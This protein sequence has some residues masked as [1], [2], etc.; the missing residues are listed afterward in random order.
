M[1]RASGYCLMNVKVIFSRNYI[2]NKISRYAIPF[3]TWFSVL[4]SLAGISFNPNN[5]SAQGTAYVQ[6]DG[7]PP[8]LESPLLADVERSY[9]QGAFRVQFVLISPSRQPR[10]FQFRLSFEHDGDQLL[11]MVSDPISFEP[12]VYSYT[13][14]DDDPAILFPLSYDE[15]L[16][17]LNPELANT[18]ILPE[19]DYLLRIE[20]IPTDPNTLIPTVPGVALFTVRYGEPPLLLTPPDQ[21]SISAQLPIFSWTPVTGV[22]L[23]STIEYELL[24]SEVLSEQTPAQA[25]ESNIEQAHKALISQTSFVYTPTELPL[26]PGK[27]YAWQVQARDINDQLPILDQG[28]TEIY[29]FMIAGEGLGTGLTAWSFPLNTPFLR[30]DFENTLDIDPN[31][32]ELFFNDYLPIDLIGIQTNAAFNN[33]SIDVETQRIIEGSIS[34]ENSFALEIAINPL[35]DSFTAYKAVTSGSNLSL[36]DGLLLD[37]GSDIFIDAEG[38]H[39]KGTH[40]A[41]ISYSGYGNEVWTSTYSEDLVLGFSPF[42]IIKGRIDFASEGVAKGYADP[43][44]FHLLTQSDPVIAQLPDRLLINGGKTGYIPLKRGANALV[45]IEEKGDTFEIT[46]TRPEGLDLVLP[47]LQKNYQSQPPRFF[48]KT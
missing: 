12:G 13:T 2:A 8:I 22:P 11:E 18:G 31:E 30:Y 33:V 38:L 27:V 43:T 32:T 29:T 41:Q 42:N 35:N 23:G 9:R 1:E 14:F 44:G 4:W 39:P 5:A 40:P 25:L 24:I 28:A 20:A 3:L 48:C 19:G 7:I 26:E 37:L 34:L 16:N 10:S 15:W 36:K 17:Q 21:S 45:S 6:I 47:P 46:S